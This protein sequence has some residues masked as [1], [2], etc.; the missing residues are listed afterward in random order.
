MFKVLGGLLLS[1]LLCGCPVM[2]QS[3]QLAGSMARDVLDAPGGYILSVAEC[4]P[5]DEDSDPEPAGWV[6]LRLAD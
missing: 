5:T 4:W 6:L 3:E 2:H 1:A